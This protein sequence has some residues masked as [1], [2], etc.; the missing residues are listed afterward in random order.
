MITKTQRAGAALLALVLG[1]LAMAKLLDVDGYASALGSFSFVDEARAWEAGTLFAAAEA[2]ASAL[3]F[4][5][6]IGGRHALVAF[7][8]GAALALAAALGYAIL[9]V[10]AFYTGDRLDDTALFGTLLAQAPRSPY[11]V[12]EVLLLLTWSAW[13]LSAS[14][15]AP[16]AVPRRRRGKGNAAPP[17]LTPVG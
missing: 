4:L 16:H 5:V 3:L 2:C 10:S 8:G 6:V 9:V 14:F 12:L 17:S 13:L 7:Q 1:A 15:L 11:V